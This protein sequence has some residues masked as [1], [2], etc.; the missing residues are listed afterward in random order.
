VTAAAGSG[1]ATGDPATAPAPDA[2]TGDAATAPTPGAVAGNQRASTTDPATGDAA[3]GRA[4]TG[5]VGDGRAATSDPAAS[6]GP[7]PGEP[8]AAP[9]TGD[10]AGG[11]VAAGGAVVGV[12]ID[13]VELDRFRRTL[14]RTPGI[15]E[16]LFTDGERAY[17]N[18]RRDPTERLAARFAAKEAAMKAMGVGLW[19]FSFRDVEVVRAA[20]GAPS[21]VL[22]GKAAE[23]AEE[24]G[25]TG[26]RLSLTHTERTAS[27]IAIAL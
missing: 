14:E 22:H 7:T 10:G 23:L 17:A 1:P 27:A 25:I 18:R 13:A 4:S 16:R 6:T 19:K 15:A 3:D 26:W 12:G 20:T 21:L 5:D 11:G 9:A 8:A 24:L 2:G